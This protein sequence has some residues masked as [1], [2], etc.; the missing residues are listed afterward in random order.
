M[1]FYKPNAPSCIRF[2]QIIHAFANFKLDH[3]VIN[4]RYLISPSPWETSI[5]AS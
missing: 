3:K 2:I 5:A 4:G 1:F